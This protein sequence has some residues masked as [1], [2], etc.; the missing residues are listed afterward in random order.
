MLGR[1]IE[2]ER[3]RQI[4]SGDDADD[5]EG[6]GASE[7]LVHLLAHAFPGNLGKG[8]RDPGVL[9]SRA[10]LGMRRRCVSRLG[11][12]EW[13]YLWVDGVS[14]TTGESDYA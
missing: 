9:Y 14:E 6:V 2:Q 1:I 4:K 7:H 3:F 12:S 8:L 13:A 10:C 11:A 5:T